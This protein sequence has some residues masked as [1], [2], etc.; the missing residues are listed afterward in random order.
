MND[1][2]LKML[3]K[4][5]APRVHVTGFAYDPG[6]IPKDRHRAAWS[7]GLYARYDLR[8]QT[9]QYFTISIFKP[10]D[11]GVARR[12]K[13]L[14]EN[15][16][17]IVL[18]DVREK[19]PLSE[20]EKLPAPTWKLE[21][22]QGSEQWGYLLDTPCTDRGRVENLLDGLLA[23]GLAPDGR[24]PGMKGVTRYVRLPDGVNSK[25]SRLVNGEPWQ[26][27]L[28]E[29]LPFNTV[30]MEQLAAPFNVD[31]DA[32]RRESRVDGAADLPDHPLL[33][34]GL[35]VK[36]IRSDGRFDITCPW[37]DE[38]TGGEDSGTAVFT[39][40]DGT[41]G[42]KCHHG[43]CQEKTGQHLLAY[44]ET[45]APG[46]KV[47]LIKY[48]SDKAFA[49]V[50]RSVPLPMSEVKESVSL[51]I[52]ALKACGPTTAEA[53]ALSADC[54]KLAESV[55][56]IDQ[57]K[58]HGEV[59][60]HMKWTQGELNAV[61]KDLRTQWYMSRTCDHSFYDNILFVADLNQ[62]YDYKKRIFFSA[63]AFQN[64]YSHEDTEARRAALE[65]GRVKKVDK[66]DYAPNFPTVFDRGG[67]VFGNSW[68]DQEVSGVAGDCARW[69]EHFKVLGWGEHTKHILQWMAHTILHPDVKINHMLMLGSAEGCGKDFILYPLLAAMGHNGRV[70]SGEELMSNFNDY[71][72]NTK[73]LHVNEVEIGDHHMAK[74]VATRLKPYGA[75][76]PATL[77]VNQKGIKV[78]EVSNILSCTMTTNS[79]VP[80]ALVGVS[81]RF[82]AV[83]SELNTRDATGN[84][85]PEWRR[86]WQDRWEWMTG[87]GAEA[88]IHYL[89]NHV[90]LEGFNPGSPPPV[91]EFLR[92]IADANKS[93]GVQTIESFIRNR[94]GIF[95]H[96]IMTAQEASETLRLGEIVHADM[97]MDR[98]KLTPI[99]V[100]RIFGDVQGCIQ[101][102]ARGDG[103]QHRVWVVRNRERYEGMTPVEIYRAWVNQG[104]IKTG[105]R[106]VQ[107]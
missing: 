75:A 105:L 57:L 103:G 19:L 8:P 45:A 54:L 37:V 3:F 17:V 1:E 7:G 42:F 32:P 31:L 53:R 20:V 26:C 50:P 22:S 16:P 40:G 2:F 100:G 47:K 104:P 78:I 59:R 64:S 90:S 27:R 18:D 13:A 85:T 46:F 97:V 69:L 11:E 34:C 89:R 98:N 92:D 4:S 51:A 36:E 107:G 60:A 55:P 74:Q 38:H 73:Y 63:E 25:A 82:Y 56:K 70:I 30:T 65:D 5:D 91:T 29:W 79:R 106:A 41:I 15:T 35:H 61:I 12:R 14:F 33:N 77:N 68:T 9:N 81:R 10:D 101:M 95:E 88:C 6:A 48:Q 99:T 58:W 49:E 94:T 52:E 39:N 87:G 44:L 93:P 66:L 102:T 86:Y 84:M 62:F 21:T 28:T 76:P 96:D 43:N 67:I 83:W 80:L 24:D 71:L 23:N 72:L